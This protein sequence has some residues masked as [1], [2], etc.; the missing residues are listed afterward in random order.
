LFG[1]WLEDPDDVGWIARRLEIG[2]RIA[3]PKA[4]TKHR[5]H[6]AENYGFL[7]TMEYLDEADEYDYC[8]FVVSYK[9]SDWFAIGA[10]WDQ[11]AD[12]ATPRSSNKHQDGEWKESGPSI[13]AILTTPRLFDFLSPY[14]ELGA[15]FPSA[16][17]DAYPWW[18]LGYPSPEYHASIGSPSTS[19]GG[20]RR[21]IDAEAA[22]SMTLLWGLGLKAYL[23]ENLA[24]DLAYRHIDCDIDANYRQMLKGRTL[25]DHGSYKIPLSYSQLC[26]GVRWAF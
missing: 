12:V 21:V 22:N 17:F 2:W 26:F 13:S 14:A 3:R 18:T 5:W 23:T 1:H 25:V 20:Y 6:D 8:N 16:S 9:L 10:S 7:G 24:L 4:D 15:H 11:I 19:N